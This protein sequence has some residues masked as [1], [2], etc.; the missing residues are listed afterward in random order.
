MAHTHETNSSCTLSTVASAS[1]F[2]EL[3]SN[4]LL[5]HT[6]DFKSGTYKSPRWYTAT[7]IV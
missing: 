5:S 7:E 2:A 3:G 1:R 4:L 6:K